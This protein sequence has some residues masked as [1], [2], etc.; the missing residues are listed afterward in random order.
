MIGFIAE[1]G[2]L[3][4]AGII[5]TAG[6]IIAIV[7]FT[8]MPKK[9]QIEVVRKW[10]LYIVIEA[11]QIFGGKTGPL[12][13]VFAYDKFIERFPTVAKILTFDRFCDLVDDA[14]EEMDEILSD[15]NV[16]SLLVGKWSG[17]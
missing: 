4:L 1:W 6:L 2:L 5:V 13:L 7:R 17:K 16:I 3:I 10:L 12:K 11:E 8:K 15:N 14:L 9:E